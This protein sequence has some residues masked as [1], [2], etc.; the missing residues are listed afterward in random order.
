MCPKF[1]ILYK[2]YNTHLFKNITPCYS[3]VLNTFDKDFWYF[4]GYLINNRKCDTEEKTVS[5]E[6]NASEYIYT[7]YYIK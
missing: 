3:L 5:S 4:K 7:L 6:N 2:K 1:Q